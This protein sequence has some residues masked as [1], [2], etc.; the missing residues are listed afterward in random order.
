MPDPSVTLRLPADLLSRIDAEAERLKVKRSDWLREA[1]EAHLESGQPAKVSPA[2]NPGRK[3]QPSGESPKLRK[4]SD[5]VKE[6]Q[7]T[8]LARAVG[9]DGVAGTDAHGRPRV[10]R[11]VNLNRTQVD[12]SFRNG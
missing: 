4:P 2:P 12:P 6:R 7:R 11:G 1:A 10:T 8:A 3:D 5:S 9:S